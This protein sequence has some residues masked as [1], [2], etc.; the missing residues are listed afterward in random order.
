M[1]ITRLWRRGACYH[2]EMFRIGRPETPGQ[3][4]AHIL[5]AIVA[6]FLVA[7]MLRVYVL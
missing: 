7:W 4:I 5:L 1:Q 3:W 2:L 6:L